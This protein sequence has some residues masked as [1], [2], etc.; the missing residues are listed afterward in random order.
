MISHMLPLMNHLPVVYPIFYDGFDTKFLE[1]LEQQEYSMP[2]PSLHQLKNKVRN[3][4]ANDVVSYSGKG[5]LI[6]IEA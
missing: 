6:Q 2:S 5:G 3:A 1:V 4:T